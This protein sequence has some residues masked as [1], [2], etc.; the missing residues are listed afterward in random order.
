MTDVSLCFG[1]YILVSAEFL[2]SLVEPSLVCVHVLESDTDIGVDIDMS[3]L[4]RGWNQPISSI[5]SWIRHNLY[6]SLILCKSHQ[7]E[8]NI[9]KLPT[10]WFQFQKLKNGSIC[11]LCGSVQSNT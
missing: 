11:Q 7:M 1:Q 6:I 2:L 5:R 10:V 8:K 9:D 3:R 4:L